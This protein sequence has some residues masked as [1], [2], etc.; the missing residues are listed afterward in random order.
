MCETSTATLVN[1]GPATRNIDEPVPGRVHVDTCIA[2]EVAELNRAGVRTLGSCCA[3]DH[4]CP[5]PGAWIA[6]E[7]ADVGLLIRLGYQPHPARFKAHPG[8]VEVTPKLA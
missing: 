5:F 3:H 8:A 7:A 2:P 6:V 1:V 4:D